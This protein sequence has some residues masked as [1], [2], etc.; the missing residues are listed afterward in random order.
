MDTTIRVKILDSDV[1][2]SLSANARGKN[3]TPT[4]LTPVMGK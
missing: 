1:Y 3:A 4:I 2:I